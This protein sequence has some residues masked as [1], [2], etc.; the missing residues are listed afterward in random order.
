MLRFCQCSLHTY[1]N[2]WQ[3]YCSARNQATATVESRPF[4]FYGIMQLS[5]TNAT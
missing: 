3:S 1:T 4:L 2:K 5:A